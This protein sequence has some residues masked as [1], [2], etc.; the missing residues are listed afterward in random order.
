[1]VINDHILG[2]YTPIDKQ[3][4]AR[5]LVNADGELYDQVKSQSTKVIEWF[6][7]KLDQPVLNNAIEKFKN[8]MIIDIADIR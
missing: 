8:E 2:N 6:M 5:C 3:I 4:L 1:V 7:S